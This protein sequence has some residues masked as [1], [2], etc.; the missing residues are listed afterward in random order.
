LSL[1]IGSDD[2]GSTN[3]FLWILGGVGVVV[4]IGGGLFYF[5]KMRD[6]DSVGF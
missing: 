1:G 2:S 4:L 6:N 5:L 3:W